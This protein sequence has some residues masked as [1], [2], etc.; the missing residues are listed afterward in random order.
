MSWEIRDGS[1]EQGR[2]RCIKI[3]DKEYINQYGFLY[4]P[5]LVLLGK[6]F[7]RALERVGAGFWSRAPLPS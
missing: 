1:E 2:H 4:I 7:H 5:H 3:T 6:V